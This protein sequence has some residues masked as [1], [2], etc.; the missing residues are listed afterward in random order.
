MLWKSGEIWQVVEGGRAVKGAITTW[1]GAHCNNQIDRSTDNFVKGGHNYRRGA[2]DNSG[3][4]RIQY[5]K[6]E[7]P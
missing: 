4:D 7:W 1:L 5:L 3:W 6:E 2:L